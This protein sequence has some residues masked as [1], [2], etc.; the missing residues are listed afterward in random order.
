MLAGQ[1]LLTSNGF[2][3]AV[4][5]S[6]FTSSGLVQ[7]ECFLAWLRDNGLLPSSLAAVRSARFPSEA[8][9]GRVVCLLSLVHEKTVLGCVPG[10]SYLIWVVSETQTRQIRCDYDLMSYIYSYQS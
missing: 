8:H 10:K 6:P 1:L 3:D 9:F 5:A 4:I 2:V 7:L